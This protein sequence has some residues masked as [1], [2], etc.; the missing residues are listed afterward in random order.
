MLCVCATA[1]LRLEFRCS[2]SETLW[3]ISL[4]CLSVSS[5][6]FSFIFLRACT[7]VC[8]S[9][10]LSL[11]A[12]LSPVVRLLHIDFLCWFGHQLDE[13]WLFRWPVAVLRCH[14]YIV[15]TVSVAQLANK[16]IDWWLTGI[17]RVSGLVLLQLLLFLHLWLN[18]KIHQISTHSFR[19]E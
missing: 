7:S 13:R 19:P 8:L 2:K 17:P 14:H 4:V 5:I 11:S 1:W 15:F 3:L 9:V 16:L 10:C 6:N 12:C 18:Y